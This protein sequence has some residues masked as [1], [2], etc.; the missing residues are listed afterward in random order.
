[1]CYTQN[2]LDFER[3]QLSTIELVRT[4]RYGTQ[5]IKHAGDSGREFVSI[6]EFVN[7]QKKNNAEVNLWK[8]DWIINVTPHNP[9]YRRRREKAIV[10]IRQYV[11]VE[12]DSFI[13]SRKMTKAKWRSEKRGASTN[14]PGYRCVFLVRWHCVRNTCWN[15]NKTAPTVFSGT[16]HEISRFIELLCWLAVRITYALD[17][18]C[19]M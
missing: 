6:R 8:L 12:M 2:Y 19:Y 7:Y 3:A 18:L 16:T 13:I 5:Y 15:K 1:M 11:S 17:Y 4:L 10:H 9:R 14:R